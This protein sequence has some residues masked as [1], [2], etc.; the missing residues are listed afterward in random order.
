MF[1]ISRKEIPKQKYNWKEN[2]FEL[3]SD[4]GDVREKLICRD[5]VRCEC[6]I[7]S[8]NIISLDRPTVFA[9]SCF[10]SFPRVQL[11][12]FCTMF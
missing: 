3:E 9:A 2:E 12:S 4:T 8:S 5:I 7:K 11:T 1:Q 10:Y 6:G